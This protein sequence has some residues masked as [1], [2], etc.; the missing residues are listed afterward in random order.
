MFS[1]L[2][3]ILL[4]GTALSAPTPRAA[5]ADSC[6]KRSQDMDLWS[7]DKFDFHASYTFSTPAH[8]NSWG[9]VNFTLGNPAVPASRPVCAAESNWLNDF[10][11]GGGQVYACDTGDDGTTSAT[12]SFSRPSG[13]LRVNQ[14]WECVDEG[15]R[16]EARG[17]VVLNLTCEEKEWTNPDWHQG[18][19]YS[20]RNIDCNVVD[21]QAPV[22]E[23][24]T[25]MRRV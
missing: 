7:V 17:G 2:S 15:G 24:S 22:E 10:F 21:A 25:V 20:T 6:V 8:Q 4:A 19:I 12:W 18:S 13:E 23:M 11:Y 1:A 14:T 9:Y 16:F 5:A 3:T